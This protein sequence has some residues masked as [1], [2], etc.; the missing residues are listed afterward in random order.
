DITIIEQDS[1][2]EQLQ[3]AKSWTITNKDLEFYPTNLPQEPKSPPLVSALKTAIEE[4][5][6]SFQF[7]GHNLG[8]KAPFSLT[9]LIGKSPFHYDVGEIKDQFTP[10][11]PIIDAEKQA[12]EVFGASNTWF[13]LGGSTCGVLAAIMGTCSPGDTLILPRNCHISVISALVLCGAIPKYV[14]PDYDSHWDFA[15]SV[16]KAIRELELEG[17]QP[18]AVLITSPTYNGICSNVTE[19]SKLC[20][21]RNIP[22][23][24]DEA[25]GAHFSF[26]PQLP[27]SSLKQGADVVVQSTHKVLLS[28]TQSS[29]LHTSQ[30]S[31]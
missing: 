6:A 30:N 10:Q 8:H 23:I 12:A 28:L 14:F 20:H 31:L 17:K 15:T 25:H 24:V 1:Y 18:A 5:H 19:I 27:I 29:M 11:S 2:Q 13:L 7:P 3:N 9:Q 22:L 16:E 26:H 21:S 4:N